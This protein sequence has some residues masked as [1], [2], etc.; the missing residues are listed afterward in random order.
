MTHCHSCGAPVELEK[1]GG[2][3]YCTHCTDAQG[4]LRPRE[5]VHHGIA[6]WLR[7]WQPNLS[8]ETALERAR[9]YMLAMPAW[10]ERK[11]GPS[12]KGG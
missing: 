1:D 10:A 7:A 9:H 5:A 3:S 2:P 6:S 4:R 8:E 11:D 12:R